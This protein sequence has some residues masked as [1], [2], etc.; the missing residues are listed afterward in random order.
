MDKITVYYKSNVLIVYK[1]V[2]ERLN[3]K[4]GQTITTEAHFWEILGQ[5][6]NH[7]ILLCNAELRPKN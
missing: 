2:A 3:L 7:G 5:N 1:S 6:A 4:N